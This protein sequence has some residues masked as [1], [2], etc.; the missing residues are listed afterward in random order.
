MA[1]NCTKVRIDY[2]METGGEIL[3]GAYDDLLL[4]FLTP[5]KLTRRQLAAHTTAGYILNETDVDHPT[6]QVL[7]DEIAAGAEE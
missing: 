4:P 7:H 1:P 3:T 5:N 2:F 6:P